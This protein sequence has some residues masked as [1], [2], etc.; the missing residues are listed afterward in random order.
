MSHLVVN[1]NN[2]IQWTLKSQ[3]VVNTACSQTPSRKQN[4][5][6]SEFLSG[7]CHFK[8]SIV[9]QIDPFSRR[10]VA[11]QSSDNVTNTCSE[12]HASVAH[13]FWIF[14]HAFDSFG[15]LLNFTVSCQAF[16]SQSVRRI[17][18]VA[19]L[20]VQSQMSR[21]HGIYRGRNSPPT[22]S[23]FSIIY[24]WFSSIL[25]FFFNLWLI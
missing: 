25:A 8:R 3:I 4:P 13:S 15:F 5:E 22:V 2:F 7:T 19:H 20:D 10:K 21:C 18:V 23:W 17:W 16:A 11:D 14:S 9:N 24:S 6:L 12:M 1:G